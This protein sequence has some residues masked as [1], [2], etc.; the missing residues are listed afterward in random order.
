MKL[1]DLLVGI[2]AEAQAALDRL[3][4]D[5]P[6]EEHLLWY[7][8]A[9]DDYRDVVEMSGARCTDH[10]FVETPTVF[11]H[12]DYDARQL[13]LDRDLLHSDYDAHVRLNERHSVALKPDAHV[14]YWVN[15]DF[16]TFA[17][18]APPDPTI[19]L[20]DLEVTSTRSPSCRRPLLYFVFENHNFLEEVVLRRG[21]AITHFVKVREGCG[22]GGCK[23]SISV[24]Y[25]L[26]ATL[27]T[28]FLFV[29]D[30]VHYSRIQHDHIARRFRVDHRDY[31]LRRVGPPVRWSDFD[32]T[33][34]AVESRDG[35]LTPQSLE[36]SLD[37]LAGEGG[38]N[39]AR[40]SVPRRRR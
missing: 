27:G 5:S 30:E 19:Y 2:T 1:R 6:E 3:L 10:G 22:F 29:D 25:S 39:Y 37:V 40:S 16:A 13:R 24:F 14:D 31:S 20:L 4:P 26:L 9:G 11:C 36:Q 18:E 33:P 21:L 12:T 17:S 35:S 23:L 28:R 8:S 38:W 34:F 7:P 15:P 32:V